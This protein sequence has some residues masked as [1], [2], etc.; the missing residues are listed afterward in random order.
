MQRSCK[1]ISIHFTSEIFGANISVGG[2]Q[3]ECA[4][5]DKSMKICIT[6][7]F[8]MLNKMGSDPDCEMPQNAIFRALNCYKSPILIFSIT[9]LKMKSIT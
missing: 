4:H 9:L 7:Q 8:D 3:N 6:T 5:R 1:P 2:K